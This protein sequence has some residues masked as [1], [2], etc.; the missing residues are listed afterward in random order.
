MSKKAAL[1]PAFLVE[2]VEATAI[3]LKNETDVQKALASSSNE[4]LHPQHMESMSALMD[5]KVGVAA[6][7]AA[8]SSK[9][10]DTTVEPL[11]KEVAELK[12]LIAKLEGRV[13][14]L[15]KKDI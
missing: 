3:A 12:E 1:P 2:L 11:R 13:Q 10:T 14:R 5:E 9:V 7:A 8:A 6:A 15:E 4:R